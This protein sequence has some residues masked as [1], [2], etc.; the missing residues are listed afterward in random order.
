MNKKILIVDDEADLADLISELFMRSGWETC[1]ACHGQEALD[2]IPNFK[3]NVILSDIT[4]PVMNGMEL[5]EEIYHL[6]L[7]LP[8]IFI[9]GFR[10]VEKMKRAWCFC[11]FDFLDKPFNEKAILQVAENAAEYGKDY[12]MAARKRYISMQHKTTKAS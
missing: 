5:L 8:L 2:K 7:N 11:A 3:P 10:D 9:T 4:M 1:I 12:V 6:E